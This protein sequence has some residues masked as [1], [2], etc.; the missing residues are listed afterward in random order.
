MKNLI[1]ATTLLASS[2]LL[3]AEA[4][5]ATLADNGLK[6][7]NAG[8]WEEALKLNGEAVEKFGQN[9]GLARNLYGPQFGVIWFRKGI[10]ELKLKKF[11]DA[12]K[13]FE[14]TYKDFPNG[15][16]AQGNPFNKMALLKWGEAALGAE[17]F[18]VAIEQWKKF[19]AERDKARDK[20]PQGAFH[21]NMAVSYYRL[22]KIAEGNEHLEIAITN[23]ATFPTPN[24][25]IVSGFQALV[26]AAI[27]ANNE[28]ALLDFVAKNKGA[29][30]VAPFEMQRFSKLFM[31][32]AGDAI[33][34]K[35]PSTALV[36]YRFVPSTQVAIDDLSSRLEDL[37]KLPKLLDGSNRLDKERMEKE[38]AALKTE[39]RSN[40]S[41]E[42]IKLA[43][44]AYIYETQGYLPS[45]Y[46]AYLQLETLYPTAEKREDNL[47][48]LIRTASM[49]NKVD[50]I[51]KYSEPFL[52]LFPSS[53]YKKDIQKLML[54]SLFFSG[55]Y[56]ESIE[57]ASDI[58]ENKRVEEGTPDH[59]FALFVLGGSYFYTG[60]YDKAA[61]FLDKHV[62]TYPESSFAMS[63]A[64]FQASN[65]YRLQYWKKAATQLDA[66][67]SK[68]KDDPNQAYMPMALYDRANTHYSEEEMEAAMEKIDRL[69]NEYPDSPLTDQAQNL[70]GNVLEGEG[71]IEDAKAAYIKA[72]ENA[73]ASGNGD[74]AGESLY[75]L[76]AL[77]AG[78]KSTEDAD[79]RY[80]EAVTY[81][82]KYWEK[83]ADGSPYKAQVAVAQVPALTA[84][85]RN[86]DALKRL[87]TVISDM[88]KMAEAV[89]LEAAINSYTEAYL[90]NHTPDQLKEH[91]YNFDGISIQDKVARAL[92]RIAVIGVFEGVMANA[93]DETKKREAKAMIQVLFQNLKTEFDLKDLSNYIL[94]KLGDYLRTNTSAPRE[95]IPYYDE[96]LSRQDQAYRFGALLGRA[97][98]YGN[99]TQDA[100][101][102]K[103]LDDFE[104][105]FADSEEKGQREFALYRIIQ[106]LMKKGDYE[107]AA[108]RANQYLNRDKESGPTLGFTKYTPEVGYI[109]AQTFDKR[110]M[111]DD[112]IAMYVKVWSAH[113]GYVAVSAP[114]IHSWME[115]Q[116][117]R[118]KTS[119]DPKVPSDRQGA[120]EGGYKYLE[121]TKNFKNKLSPEDLALWEKVE[122]LTDKYVA[123]PN[124]KSMEQLKKEK[125]EK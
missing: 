39:L 76:I 85:G 106:I 10:A 11:E 104:R 12:M 101:L 107:E 119:S 103:A 40:K 111:V 124:V 75:Y 116:H 23:K 7:M 2:A 79:A 9:P 72:F 24:T 65:T 83:Y 51:Q 20:Y 43:A 62:E 109:L 100:D 28:Q 81:S 8:K 70:K 113:M 1:I 35:M 89:G 82:D 98:V 57:I 95:A 114:A 55:K 56:E 59:D 61:P 16:D 71:K 18:D 93:E 80:K 45:A 78:D 33:A 34:A 73:E 122:K 99:S 117:K 36:L 38:L 94:V 52:K 46:A 5:L 58:I 30:M 67:I 87:Q 110:N 47:Y 63:V 92:L 74:V 29:L 37:G 49:L 44:I 53:K 84:Q 123:D 121:I 17:K 54:S 125:E 31:K 27:E 68:Y 21:V 60:Q 25:A 77:L 112:A 102:K 97:D 41:L 115:L 120:Y 15:E 90:E 91:Y 50:Q 22:G 32:L 19:L 66:F 86:E 88:A 3:H 108:K 4:D 14:A 26:S 42:M 69:I 96:A 13:S 48:N 118:N 105:I 6:A 64:Y